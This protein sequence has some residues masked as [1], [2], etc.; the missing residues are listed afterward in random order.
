MKLTKKHLKALIQEELDNMGEGFRTDR[1]DATKNITT[2]LGMDKDTPSKLATL[3]D[4]A[5]G[6]G[7]AALRK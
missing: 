4:Q 5:T 3:G 6:A 1:K 2:D 7:A